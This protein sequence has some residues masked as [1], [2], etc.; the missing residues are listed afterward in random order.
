MLNAL[1]AGEVKIKHRPRGRKVLF[2]LLPSD[3]QREEGN[4]H[5]TDSTLA[6]SQTWVDEHM[7]DDPNE[8]P[9]EEMQFEPSELPIIPRPLPPRRESSVWERFGKIRIE[10][11]DS[12]DEDRVPEPPWKTAMREFTRPQ[13]DDAS[14]NEGKAAS[15]PVQSSDEEEE[16]ELSINHLLPP[17]IPHMLQGKGRVILNRDDQFEWVPNNPYATD[18]PP[19]RVVW[20]PS[21]SK[22][23]LMGQMRDMDRWARGFVPVDI[24]NRVGGKILGK[25]VCEHNAIRKV[26]EC[27][28]VGRKVFGDLRW[29]PDICSWE[30][31]LQDADGRRKWLTR[32]TPD[33]EYESSREGTLSPMSI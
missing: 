29:S 6:F 24:P 32:L 1:K 14:D 20:C 2:H 11:S 25:G 5:G 22:W 15:I 27:S 16:V 3:T 30:W 21:K 9:D 7:I 17:R 28:F 23:K 12:E 33:R 4:K 8:L 10:E 26:W 19:E 18:C 31:F 13:Y